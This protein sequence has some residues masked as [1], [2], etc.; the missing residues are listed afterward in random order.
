MGTGLPLTAAP[1]GAFG[2]GAKVLKCII[3]GTLLSRL[4]GA[5]MGAGPEFTSGRRTVSTPMLPA[6]GEP[7][8]RLDQLGAVLGSGLTGRSLGPRSAPAATV[9]ASSEPSA[10]EIPWAEIVMPTVT[11]ESFAVVAPLTR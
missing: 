3:S 4:D 5:D 2:R 11:S 6:T 9:V 7:A 1:R 10:R 8:L